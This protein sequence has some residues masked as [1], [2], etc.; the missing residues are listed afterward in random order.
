[1]KFEISV[2]ILSSIIRKLSSKFSC[3][4]ILCCLSKTEKSHK[5]VLPFKIFL[6]VKKLKYHQFKYC[7]LTG[8]MKLFLKAVFLF[9]NYKLKTYATIK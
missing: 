5:I 8:K 6:M 3:F 9:V 4:V 2:E 7:I 1:M